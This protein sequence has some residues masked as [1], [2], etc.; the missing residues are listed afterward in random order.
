MPPGQ[1][2]ADE[3]VPKLDA[4]PSTRHLLDQIH[5]NDIA[6]SGHAGLL[7]HGQKRLLGPRQGLLEQPVRDG[8]LGR[9]T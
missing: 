6:G 9:V 5:Q 3:A 7:G 8:P 2:A 1:H 4:L